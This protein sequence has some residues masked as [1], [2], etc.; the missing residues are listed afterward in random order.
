MLVLSRKEGESVRIGRDVVVTVVKLRS[1]RVKIGVSAPEAVKV[2]R[3]ELVDRDGGKQ[4]N[5]A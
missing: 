4:R 3:S 1:G 5:A 2:L